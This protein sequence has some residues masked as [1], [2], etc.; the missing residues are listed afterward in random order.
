LLLMIE[1]CV[2]YAWENEWLRWNCCCYHV[3]FDD[4]DDNGKLEIEEGRTK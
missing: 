4:D 2:C 3:E 1:W